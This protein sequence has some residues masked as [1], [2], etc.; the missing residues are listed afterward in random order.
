MG[1]GN[2]STLENDKQKSLLSN[3]NNYKKDDNIDN[4]EIKNNNKK[5]DNVKND[6]KK[7]DSKKNDFKKNKVLSEKE[8]MALEKRKQD[9]N[10][11]KEKMLKE[12][13]EYQKLIKRKRRFLNKNGEYEES[14]DSDSRL[15]YAKGKNLG[16]KR[17]KLTPEEIEDGIM[18][19]KKEEDK[20]KGRKAYFSPMQKEVPF[21]HKE[22]EG[23]YDPNTSKPYSLGYEDEIYRD[24]NYGKPI[25][26]YNQTWLTYDAPIEADMYGPRVMIPPGWR[27]PTLKDYKNL[28]KFIDNNNEKLKIFL[29]H[30]KLFNMKTEYLYITSDK[31]F[32]E[33]YNGYNSKAWAYFCIGFNFYDE[34]EYPG[35]EPLIPP[36]KPKK[37]IN[38]IGND[39][40][41]NIINSNIKEKIS[42]NNEPFEDAI[43]SDDDDDFIKKMK[44]QLKQN[45]EDYGP[46]VED[47]IRKKNRLYTPNFKDN[48]IYNELNEIDKRKNYINKE[49]IDDDEEIKN[50]NNED[51]EINEDE[52]PKK[53]IFSV[54]TYKYAKKIRC[55]LI[56]NEVLDLTFKC[57]LVIE[58]GYRSF[59]EIPKLYNITTFLWNFNDEY[60]KEIFKTS[61]KLVASHVFIEPG[62]YRIDLEIELFSS[63]VFHLSKKVWVIEEI[64]FGDE[65]I[66]DGINYGQPIK[67]GN[68]YWL[69]RD[70][71]SNKNY[72]GKE[73]NLI[74]GKGPGIHGENCYL[75][76]IYA[77][78]NGWRLPL[79]EEVE[80]L[81][82][83]SGKNDE[84]KK[85]FFTSL[86]GGFVANLDEGG[87][88][89]MICLG[90][91]NISKFEDY[92]NDV[93]NGVY[94][95]L[96]SDTKFVQTKEEIDEIKNLFKDIENNNNNI[97]KA[98][99]QKLK[100]F[101]NIILNNYN[102]SDIF[103]KELNSLHI[104]N[105][106]VKMSFR[107]TQM[108]SPYS[109]FNTRC[110]LD[111]KLD[112]DL[113]I[114]ESN[115][116]VKTQINFSLNYPN[117]TGAIWNFGDDSKIIKDKL[118]VSHLYKEPKE[119]EIKVEVILFGE[120]HYEIKRKINILPQK[121]ETKLE[122]ADDII[123]VALGDY[124]QVKQ[125]A[126]IHFSHS[127][128]PI[129][130]FLKENG[131][132]ISYNEETTNMLKLCQVYFNRR[133]E[134]IYGFFETPLYE[135]E[136][137]FPLDI[138]CTDIGCCLL[139]KDSRE[140]NNLYIE[141]VS[142]E[143]ELLWRNNIMQNGENPIK[144]KIN[145]LLFYNIYKEK[146]EYGIEAM[147]HPYCGRLAYGNGRIA[148]IFSYKNNFCGKDKE[149][150][151]DNSADIIITY[152]EDGTEVNLVCPWSTSH[153]LTQR[154]LFDGKYF[155]TASLGDSEPHNIK[156][157][158][159]EPNL[160]IHLG[161][162]NPPNRIGKNNLLNKEL[163]K[164]EE[165]KEEEK[166]EEKKED[167][168]D[169][170]DNIKENE[171]KKEDKKEEEKKEEEK[172]NNKE[173]KEEERKEENKKEESKNGENK[174]EEN[175]KE[176]K[177]NLESKNEENKNN[178]S[179]KEESKSEGN[180]NISELI[181]EKDKNEKEEK[182]DE[183]EEQITPQIKNKDIN[184]QF[185]FPL[186]NK[187]LN[188]SEM[189]NIESDK[190]LKDSFH[191]KNFEYYRQMEH[192]KMS[193]R[194][195]YIS[196]NI[197]E[198]QI[199]G[200]FAGYSSGRMGGLHLL[201]NNKILMIY[202]RIECD[203]DC[204]NKNDKS[205]LCFLTF[206]N[207]LKVD[208]T[209]S[210]R[211][212]KHI[213]CIKH[214]RY[215]DNIFLMISETTKVTDDRK[216]IYDKYSFF[217]EEI[218]EDHQPCNCFLIDENGEIKSDLISFD[219]NFFSPNDDFETLKDGSTVWTFVDD[220]NNL[221][222]CFLACKQTLSYLNK[223]PDELIPAGKYNEYLYKK[224][225]EE[226]EE[227]K[228]KEKEFLKSI[229]IDDE[230]MKKKLLESELMEK[231]RI[232]KELEQKRLE[233]EMK[234]EEEEK[235]RREE[236]EKNRMLKEI[237]EEA[238][239][240][241]KM[242]KK[243]EE[244]ERK[245]KEEDE[246]RKKK[247]KNRGKDWDFSESSEEEEEE[248]EEEK[249][250]DDNLSN[251]FM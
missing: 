153:S 235:K 119:Y 100:N 105:N 107:T 44:K 88:Y 36:N 57:P 87:F 20:R 158:R 27:I 176:E 99:F 45:K 40:N 174:N 117:I 191:S 208:K 74:R 31:V 65:I 17:K 236:E 212:G 165:E 18:Q 49:N 35:I 149:E 241:E 197:V 238:R 201:P 205:E 68:Q 6:N 48:S 246:K 160:P 55:K 78:P 228:R 182:K 224:R 248:E 239:L 76:S 240:R 179:K 249:K 166:V 250:E 109:I 101:Y 114:K 183:E 187:L 226:E 148:C 69:D 3:S 146:L 92:I 186:Q 39:N 168:K 196:K 13:K 94:G 122:S 50:N 180:M 93:K 161:N 209:I 7:S 86:E 1:C 127:S 59:F 56:A 126:D 202:S 110:I 95:K 243:Q 130:P 25:K 28:F 10:K 214:A 83:Y 229:G 206:N 210:F 14:E 150:R 102:Y 75:E 223:F 231:E 225:E 79:K 220:D 42:E 77:C 237:E 141:M 199:P 234:A 192:L 47:D 72:E 233:D 154:A 54:N 147:F 73:I 29:T 244:E 23:P 132:Y 172:E 64:L 189:L 58:A 53:F 4:I 137:G 82:E 125:T 143:G 216:Y 30:E 215:G 62:E 134:F 116:Y 12:M 98:F 81:L 26:L 71:L 167:K 91:K 67:I 21:K 111:Q 80:K 194:H 211:N 136:G 221:Y 188:N 178:E 52:R 190:A 184:L 123:I 193:I 219:F 22:S 38:I 90:F 169:D 108:N 159:F 145:Q 37:I 232:A 2:V 170:N 203:N 140:E 8:Q 70:I 121:Q 124:S 157:V 104:Q 84:Q 63:R 131:F 129:S 195:K 33:D 46:L 164:I 112:L 113:G 245:K 230:L 242:R 115:F 175:K 163:E 185:Y 222:L 16:K 138:V 60:S 51:E 135:E 142:H 128:A 171:E 204:G 133:A 156:V 198:G 162:Y 106:I 43:V 251:Y 173:I 97:D 61:D 15:Q 151:I 11:K 213:N 9:R 181:D 41:N 32:P 177:K 139:I 120:I 19:D 218:E 118:Q 207:Q 34:I 152:S 155:I 144:A 247:K 5:E 89:D 217:S 96:I 66:L 103:N 24:I 85:F 227:K 200:N